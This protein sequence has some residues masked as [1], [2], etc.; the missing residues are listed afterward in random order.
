MIPGESSHIPAS[1][2][3]EGEDKQE[4]TSHTGSNLLVNTMHTSDRMSSTAGRVDLLE[5]FERIALYVN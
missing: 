2:H 1:N 5:S 3:M 4:K